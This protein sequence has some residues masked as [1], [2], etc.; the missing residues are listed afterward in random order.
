MKTLP[1]L[2]VFYPAYNDS[3]SLPSLIRD[4]YK[5]LPKITND[6]EVIIINDG[7]KDSTQKVAEGLQKKYKH[8]LL[9]NHKK[10]RGYGGALQTG[11]KKAT[12]EWIFYTDG[13]GQYNPQEL[14]KLVQL[15]TDKTTAVNGYKLQRHDSFIRIYI[16][17]IYNIVIHLLYPIPIKDVDCDFRL[18]HSSLLK[19]MRLSSTSALI[20]LELILKISQNG[21]TFKQIEVSHI[22]RKY[23]SSQ[24]FN[25]K[26]ILQSL[27][28]HLSFYI[29]T[30]GGRKLERV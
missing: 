14:K 1:S 29:R 22:E 27:R 8:L 10:N 13:D 9:V 30:V 19:K 23:G 12:K 21:A 24:F 20:C 18:I 11:F 16:G 15:A 6:Y 25:I 5:V 3:Q 28:E 26:N 2:S 4:T 17:K 7:S